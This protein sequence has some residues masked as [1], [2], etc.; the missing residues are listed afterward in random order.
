MNNTIIDF[1]NLKEEEIE[2]ISTQSTPSELIVSLSLNKQF[3][4]CPLCKIK[5]NKIKNTYLRKINHGIFISRKCTVL[6]NQKRYYC[7]V[8]R[9]TFTEPNT[10]VNKSQ[11]KSL[12]S[13][14]QVMELLKSPQL[15]F[16]K[17]GELL[18]LSTTSVQQIFIK[19][20]PNFQ[21]SLPQVLCIDEVYLGKNA[22]KKY[23]AV[24]MDFES[25]EIIDIIYG[26]S[27][28]ALHSY[29][30]RIPL[31]ERENVKFMSTDMY[32]GFRF[33]KQHYLKKTKVCVDQFHVIQLILVMFD[34]QIKKIMNQLDRESIDYYLL[35]NKRELLLMNEYRVIWSER[36]YNRK[37]RYT[38]SNYKLR[39][40]IFE[41][42]PLIKQLYQLKEEYI[43]INGIKNQEEAKERLDIY[44]LKCLHFPHPDVRRV[45]RTLSKW[46][47]E[48]VN[49]FTWF[50]DRRISNGAIES[51]NNIIKL[52]IRNAAGYRNFDNLRLRIIYCINQKKK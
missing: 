2:S 19:H 41:I 43:R 14:I 10:L 46:S 5:T 11:K 34:K 31:E 13:V 21:R 51:R 23:V 22:T 35:K 28:D 9:S 29:F 20:C 30:Q 12:S 39:E 26:R 24:L 47:Q 6:F 45:G 18:H 37:L 44:I 36:K 48:I 42:N 38:V 40:M 50:G 16:K 15:T 4:P 1:L 33:L 7:P 3:L 27:K 17:V 25:M 8:C 32:E 52:I 49:S